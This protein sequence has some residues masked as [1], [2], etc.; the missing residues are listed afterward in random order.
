MFTFLFV[1]LR[2]EEIL[3]RSI[4]SFRKVKLDTSALWILGKVYVTANV[5][6]SYYL[7][8][9]ECR[10]M[11]NFCNLSNSAQLLRKCSRIF[12]LLLRKCRSER[13]FG[14][15][16]SLTL[17]YVM[18]RKCSRLFTSHLTWVSFYGE[19]LENQFID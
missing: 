16:G 19:F 17:I 11:E 13:F 3:I 8:K 5:F 1:I 7:I 10:S 6:L 18:L 12:T 15:L 9:N 14:F 2:L 4:K